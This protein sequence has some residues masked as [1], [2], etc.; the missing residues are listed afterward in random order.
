MTNDV[1]LFTVSENLR[2]IRIFLS[3][4]WRADLRRDGISSGMMFTEKIS[5]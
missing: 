2:I 5:V 4:K 3:P 1:D